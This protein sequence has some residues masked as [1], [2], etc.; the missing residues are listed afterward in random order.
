MHVVIIRKCEGLLV[1]FAIR[2]YRWPQSMS[3][4]M[5]ARLRHSNLKAA[6]FHVTNLLASTDNLPRPARRLTNLL[7]F[8]QNKILH[9]N[10]ATRFSH[11]HDTK[12]HI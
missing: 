5:H 7:S 6:G 12:F 11:E 8:S 9:H 4:N 10:Q 2:K 1:Q 3:R